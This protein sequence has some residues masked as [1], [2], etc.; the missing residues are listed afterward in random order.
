M[1][2]NKQKLVWGIFLL[3][4][5]KLARRVVNDYQKCLFYLWIILDPSSM[6]FIYLVAALKTGY[7]L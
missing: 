7:M 3:C 6:L 1:W 5:A 2:E 4:Q